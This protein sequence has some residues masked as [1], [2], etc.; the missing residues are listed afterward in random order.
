VKPNWIEP[1]WGFPKG[2]RNYNE[3]DMDCAIRE[4]GEET[5]INIDKDR[6][7]MNIAPYEEKFCGSNYKTYKNK[8]LLANLEYEPVSLVPDQD[9]NEI[10]AIKWKTF[11]ECIACMRPYNLE[12]KRI[13]SSI[14][15]LLKTLVAF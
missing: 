9:C 2:K 10:S 1:E 13:L 8:Y 4:F 11:K 7:I 5:G 12:K 14:D 15:I 6:I 3:S